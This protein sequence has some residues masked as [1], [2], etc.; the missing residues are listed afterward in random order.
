MQDCLSGSHNNSID[1]CDIFDDAVLGDQR[2]GEFILEM[3]DFMLEMMDFI[4]DN[5]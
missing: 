2:A 5:D 3:M 1:G 4:L